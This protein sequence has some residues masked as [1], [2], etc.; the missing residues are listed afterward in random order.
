[1]YASIYSLCITVLI[2]VAIAA[3]I[4]LRGTDGQRIPS[5]YWTMR[6]HRSIWPR[7]RKRHVR[8]PSV[9]NRWITDGANDGQRKR[10]CPTVLWIF[11]QSSMEGKFQSDWP[12]QLLTRS[13]QNFGIVCAFGAGFI[14]TYLFLTEF[15]TG[16]SG[17]SSSMLFKRGSKP[18][19]LQEAEAE[20]KNSDVEKPSSSSGSGSSQTEVEEAREAAADAP[21]MT[22]IFSWQHLN[23]T[24]PVGHKET[25]KLLDDVS[26]YVAPGK[27]TALVGA[28]GA[29]KVRPF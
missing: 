20:V 25:R 18:P 26:G 21:A 22:D 12:E 10:L 16:S 5:T 13:L 9:Y 28:S 14:F 17:D 7:I 27:L 15:N 23:Y 8:Q 2:C 4:W 29:G 24:I 19:V 3:E 1:M 11:V 6:S